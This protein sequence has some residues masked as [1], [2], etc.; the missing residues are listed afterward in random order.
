MLFELLRRIQ[1]I[2]NPEMIRH[3]RRGPIDVSVGG[4]QEP[5]QDP[6]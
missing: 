6:S 5:G 1:A 2:S 4:S 3:L